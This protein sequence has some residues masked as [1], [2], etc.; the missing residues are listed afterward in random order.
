MS[1]RLRSQKE[2]EDGVERVFERMVKGM[3]NEMSTVM[4]KIER[5]RDISPEALKNMVRNGL[6]AMVGAVEK[7]MYG[8]SDGLAKERKEKDEREED[9][10]WRLARENEIREE[11]RRKEEE[12]V[13]KLEE[14]LERVTKENEE[15]WKERD[16]RMR[17]VEDM[18]ERE[19]VR[20][21]GE[22]RKSKEQSRN[23]VEERWESEITNTKERITVLEDRIREGENAPGKKDSEAHAR[24]DQIE[25]DIAQDRAERKEFEWNSEGEKGIQDAKDSE[26]DMEKK[27]EGAMEQVK[28][29]NLDFGKECADGKILIKEAASRIKE[30][31]RESD[32]EEFERI[33]KGARIEIL[34]KGTSMKESGKGSIHTVP[35]LI[36]CGCKNAKG[37]LEEIVRKAGL[38]A[39]FQWPKE[40]MEFV[41]KIRGKV[42]TMGYGKKEHFTRVRPAMVQ[43]RILLRVD[44]KRKGGGKFEGLAYWRVPPSD[45]ECWKRIIN[46]M[47]PEWMIAK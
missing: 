10:K 21:A 24:I 43:G 45:K 38:V 40:C 31:V 19:A 3:R 11:R 42:E 34:G 27:L 5:S 47:E 28:I 41:D 33:M 17:V 20:K 26:K 7:A 14:K 8:I 44:T 22:V 2:E 46:M 32:K 9:K 36:T 30:T 39:T 6:D 29:L 18:M 16:E 13:R 1:R 12:R 25:K 4:W 37:R 15:R 23:T 35:V